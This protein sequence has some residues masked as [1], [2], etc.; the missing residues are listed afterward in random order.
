[1]VEK[2]SVIIVAGRWTWKCIYISY[3][4]I[5]PIMLMISLSFWNTTYFVTKH[6]GRADKPKALNWEKITLPFQQRWKLSAVKH[7]YF[8]YKKWDGALHGE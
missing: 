2:S 8:F 3:V 4:N 5:L 7:W 6:A 1:M